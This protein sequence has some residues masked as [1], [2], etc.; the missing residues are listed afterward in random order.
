MVSNLQ[1]NYPDNAYTA[2]DGLVPETIQYLLSDT[3]VNDDHG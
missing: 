3:D 1:T 2:A